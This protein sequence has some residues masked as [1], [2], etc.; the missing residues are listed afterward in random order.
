MQSILSKINAAKQLAPNLN[1]IDT[2]D[3]PDPGCQGLKPDIGIYHSSCTP[4][5]VNDFSQME[6]WVEFKYN[7]DHDAFQDNAKPNETSD[8]SDESSHFEHNSQ[9]SQLRRGQIASYTA[10]HLGSQFRTHIFSLLICGS[11]A[12]FIRWDQ[13]SAI[14]SEHFNYVKDGHYLVEFISRYNSLNH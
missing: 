8:R 3:N 10:A 9:Q 11:F 1:F 14:V 5:R 4:S 7:T 13:A 2:S 6:F 12:R